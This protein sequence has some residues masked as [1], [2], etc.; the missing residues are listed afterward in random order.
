MVV[1]P[2]VFCARRGQ[3]VRDAAE[4]L[5]YTYLYVRMLRNPSLYGITAGEADSDPTLLQRRLDLCHTAATLLD[6]HHLIK[7]DRKG[8]AFQVTAL[9][10]VASHYYVSHST[11]ATYNEH[12]KP[13]M[14]DIE[15]FR[16]FSLSGEFKYIHV[17]D[18]EKLELAKLA[19]RIP[20]PI[21]EAMDEPS[22][23][24][25]VLLQAYIS[26]LALEGFALVSDLTFVRQSA[27][28]LCRALFEIALRRGWAAM[29]DKGLNLCKMVERRMWLSQSPLRQFKGVP[30]MIVRKLEKKEIAWDR[31]YD[32]KPQDLGELVKLPKMGKTLHRLVHQA[33]TRVER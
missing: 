7:Y 23:K 1:P 28:R 14:S 6:K 11:M 33:C 8:G 12:M 3:S 29:A 13:T 22:A 25:N 31:Y 5:S 26:N 10:R 2:V 17:R 24:I 20:I 18:E 16:L 32:L 9:G 27:A 4:W 15:L 30:E 21:K 19:A